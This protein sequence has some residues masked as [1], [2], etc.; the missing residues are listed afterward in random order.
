MDRHD[1][2]PMGR[3]WSQIEENIERRKQDPFFYEKQT[4]RI[5]NKIFVAQ[6]SVSI[7]IIIFGILS[8]L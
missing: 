2:H 5:A 8:T 6:M 1:K 4:R 7:M 3:R